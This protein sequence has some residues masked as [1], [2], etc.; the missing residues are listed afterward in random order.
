LNQAESLNEL[1]GLF[2]SPA[3]WSIRRVAWEKEYPT[4]PYRAT[5]TARTCRRRKLHIEEFVLALS[6]TCSI[7][8]SERSRSG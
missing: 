2:F 5:I 7:M 6:G 3:S 8:L 4:H 1:S